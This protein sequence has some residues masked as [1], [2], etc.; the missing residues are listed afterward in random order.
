MKFLKQ[1]LSSL[2]IGTCL[3]LLMIAS[4]GVNSVKDPELAPFINSYVRILKKLD[5]EFYKIE[6]VSVKL[7]KMDRK[8]MGSF[9][10]YKNLV[11]INTEHW[12]NLSIISKEQL[13]FHELSHVLGL[14][15]EEPYSIMQPTG[16][17]P[18]RI[19]KLYYSYFINNLFKT[20]PTNKFNYIEYKEHR[21]TNEVKLTKAELLDNEH[22][23][24]RFTA[25][26]CGP[27]RA[28][29]PVFEE[30]AKENPSVKT[31]VVDVDQYQDLAAA[32]G[33]KGIP[34]CM[35]IRKKNVDQTLVGNQPKPELERLFK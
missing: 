35:A 28:L 27:C 11:A 2:F 3:G 26:W 23:V 9:F 30:L 31:Y 4:P 18:D 17:I 7:E 6:H 32:F 25:T 22:A 5:L 29:A 14:Q 24:V 16:L 19:Y 20:K 10:P 33:V 15:H 12:K 13:I 1:S 21:L 8:Y 34:M